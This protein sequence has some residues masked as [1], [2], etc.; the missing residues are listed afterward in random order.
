MLSGTPL[1]N[2]LEE[3]YSV[4]QFVDQ[5]CLGPYYKFIADTVIKSDTGKVMGYKGLNAVGEKLH[6]ILIR[7]RKKDVALQL[8]QRMDKVLFVPMTEQQQAMH[9]ELQSNVAQLVYKWN[10][11]RFLSEKDRKRLLL[12]LSQMRMVCDSTYILDQK[13]RYD[14]KI[15]ETMNILNQ[16][17]ENGDEKVVIFSQWERMTR[18]VAAELDKLGVR[19]EYLHGGVPSEKRKNLMENFT[20]LPESRVFI[21]TDAG[22]TGLNLQVASILINLDLPWNPAVLEQRIARI[23]RI[24]QQRNIQIINLVV[25]HRRA[26]ALYAQ[27]QDFALRRHLRQWRRQHLLRRWQAG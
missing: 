8:P 15:D 19:Y 4:V 17:F 20:E 2:K 9:D 11:Q 25:F 16:V 27:F 24:G 23:Y 22:S 1:E 3:L 7:R 26:D 14:T 21:S 12:S 5:Y 6:D 18:L 13:S 10:R